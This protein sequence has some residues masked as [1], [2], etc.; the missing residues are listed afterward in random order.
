MKSRML[1]KTTD[2][3]LLPCESR[4]EATHLEIYL[5]IEFAPLRMRIVPI[6]TNGRREGTQNWSWNGDLDAPTLHPSILTRW[7]GGDPFVKI[8]CH[9]FVN[10]G[11]VTFLGDCTHSL[12]G[13]DLP[14]LDFEWDDTF[15]KGVSK[16][17]EAL[18]HEN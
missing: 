7:E 12:A 9:S 13:K 18:E 8:V 2:G 4:D 11:V 3:N 5:P 1:R 14:L 10:N 17:G 6:Q 16:I 15:D